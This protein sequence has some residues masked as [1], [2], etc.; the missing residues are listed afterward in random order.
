L[1]PMVVALLPQ[2]RSSLCPAPW[3]RLVPPE[4][5]SNCSERFIQSGALISGGCVEAGSLSDTHLQPNRMSWHCRNQI[6]FQITRI[7][8]TTLVPTF[9]CKNC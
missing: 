4:V 2:S 9:S 7:A 6:L 8:P 1:A 5:L 3:L